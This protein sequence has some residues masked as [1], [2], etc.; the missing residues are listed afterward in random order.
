MSVG[1]RNMQRSYKPEV[2]FTLI[3]PLTHSLLTHRQ[4]GELL[5]LGVVRDDFEYT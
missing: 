2:P 1:S 3:L 5:S 4:V